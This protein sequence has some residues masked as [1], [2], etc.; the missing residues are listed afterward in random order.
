MHSIRGVVFESV[1]LPITSATPTTPPSGTRGP[2]INA[3]CSN[4]FYVTNEVHDYVY[5]YCWTVCYNFV[6]ERAGLELYEEREV[7]YAVIVGSFFRY[8]YLY[9]IMYVV[10]NPGLVGTLTTPNR[11]AAL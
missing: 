8:E 10:V 1:N 3:A 5:K 4:V 9:L 2:N 11:D 7:S 6:D